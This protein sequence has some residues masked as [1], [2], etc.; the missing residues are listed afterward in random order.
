MC[1]IHIIASKDEVIMK[2]CSRCKEEKDKETF[3]R[4]RRN[5][6]GLSYECKVCLSERKKKSYDPE[7]YKTDEYREK[8]RIKSQEFRWSNPEKAS[9]ISK[10]WAQ[11][12]RQ[13]RREYQEKWRRANLK[14]K[15]A[16]A[17]IQRYIKKGIVIRSTKCTTCQ[18]QGKTEAH[19]DDYNKPLEVL[20]LCRRCHMKLHRGPK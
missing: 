1:D 8:N 14:Q 13:K 5:K 15:A 9:Q 6:D 7:K 17:Y 12:N 18:A 19:H 2:V 3:C 10:N 4:E 11:Q 20:W 16:N